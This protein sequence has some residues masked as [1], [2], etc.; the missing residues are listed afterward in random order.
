[1]HPITQKSIDSLIAHI[2]DD[3]LATEVEVVGAG[4]AILQVADRSQH[5][6]ASAILPPVT[7][8]AADDVVADILVP[9][10]GAI[11]VVRPVIAELARA[12]LEEQL[13]ADD[14]VPLTL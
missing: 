5:L 4:P 7:V 11:R 9:Q 14:R 3:H 1:L 13:V 6:I 8:C 12:H 2:P 10:P